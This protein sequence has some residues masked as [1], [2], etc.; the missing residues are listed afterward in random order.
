[1]N[2]FQE[3]A[4]AFLVLA[5]FSLLPFLFLGMTA[6]VKIATC[7]HIARK[8]IG[9]DAIPENGVI[10]ALA[11]ALT[12][13]AMAPVVTEIETRAAPILLEAKST[14]DP[15]ANQA[16]ILE[17][18][19]AVREPL[20]TFLTANSAAG[21]KA[22]FLAVAQKRGANVE[23][24]DFPVLVPAFVVTELSEAFAIGFL[25]FLPFLVIDV[26]VANVLAALGTQN[27][28]AREVSLPLKLLL[29]VA[30]DG[31]GLLARALVA[32]Y[33]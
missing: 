24:T 8:A 30:A 20:R 23:A 2:L 7:L 25:I 21:E 22:R 31:W 15:T 3:P 12:L 11:A 28:S 16:Q 1:V 26:L 6:Y 32:G 27:L 9:A 33:K 5:G 4:S 19:A 18:V 10:V 14:K 29:F 13:L 17:A